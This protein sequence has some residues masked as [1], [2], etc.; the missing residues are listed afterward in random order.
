MSAQHQIKTGVGGLAVDFRSVREQ[1]SDTTIWNI[2]RRLFEV[3]CAV[4]MRV[5]HPRE[6]DRSRAA[7]YGDA[8]VEK[9]ANTERFKVRNHGNRIVVAEHSIDVAAKRLAEAR[10]D[11]EAGLAI[12][13]SA[14]AIIASQHTEIVLKV[15]RELTDPLHGRAA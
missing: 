12:A 13:V 7:A 6:I 9:H 8:F 5:V 15:V 10:H 4:E 3:V 1:D 11:F 14:P 2:P